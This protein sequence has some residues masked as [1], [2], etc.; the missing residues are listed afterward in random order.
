MNGEAFHLREIKTDASVNVRAATSSDLDAILDIEGKS[1][2]SPWSRETLLEELDG[3]AWSY[4]QA[5]ELQNAVVGFIVYWIVLN[6]IHLLNLAVH[7]DWRRMGIAAAMMHHLLANAKSHDVSEIF[8]EVRVS[9]RNAQTLY[10]R[11]GFKPIGM[12]RNYYTDNGED[13]IVMC[14]RREP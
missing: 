5:A 1:F 4:V 7:P 2:T 11:F 13:A 14:L 8:L 12:R 3:K 10:R 9:N 6:E